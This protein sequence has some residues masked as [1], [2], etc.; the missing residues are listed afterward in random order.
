MISMIAYKQDSDLIVSLNI[1]QDIREEEGLLNY[2][3]MKMNVTK[4]ITT[5]TTTIAPSSVPLS[6]IF[7]I[8]SLP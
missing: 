3:D 2:D 4:A 7:D 1:D 6:L 5:T 8:L